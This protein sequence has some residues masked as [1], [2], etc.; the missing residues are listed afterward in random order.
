[1]DKKAEIQSRLVKAKAKQEGLPFRAALREEVL[2]IK[3]FE[4]YSEKIN[5]G[6]AD[7]YIEL[8]DLNVSINK[9]IE[10]SQSNKDDVV[11][12]VG[13]DQYSEKLIDVNNSVIKLQTELLDKGLRVKS[14]EKLEAITKDVVKSIK[15]IE[16]PTSMNIK[17]L[18][19]GLASDKTLDQVNKNLLG[20]TK[21]LKALEPKPLGRLPEDYVP[22]RRVISDGNRLYFDDFVAGGGAGGG[23]GGGDGAI[24]DGVDPTI[25]AT[26]KD[27]GTQI[28]T[29]DNGL[30]TNAVIHGLTTGGGGGYVDVKV[31][32]SGALTVDSTI[33]GTVVAFAKSTEQY[34][35]NDKE[36]TATYK[37][38]GFQ[39]S[40]GGWYIMR[41]TIA[42][43]IFQYVA[44]VAPYSTA[45]TNRATQTYTD[46]ATAF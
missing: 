11:S 14:V 10:S 35:I 1:M 4:N 16:L 23:S 12:A 9:L 24:L 28:T 32:P 34:A 31:N 30:V 42:T 44:G 6:I 39:K 40:D 36:A 26:V 37:Y 18:P 3:G 7:L 43:N 17:S 27:I 19:K 22:F 46:Y 38:F 8:E 15:A 45:W 13:K 5:G 29:N 21:Q 33:S 25:K 20:I 2:Q 41:K